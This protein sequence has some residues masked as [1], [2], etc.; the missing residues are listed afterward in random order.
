[1]VTAYTMRA[2][3]R[4]CEASGV[5]TTDG[6]V[7]E[8]NGQ[9]VV[10]CARCNRHV[11]N[12]PRLETGRAVRTVTT[13]HNGIKPSQRARVLERDGRCILCGSRDGLHVGHLLSVAAG[14]E[15]GLTEAQLNDDENLAAMCAECN[16]GYGQRSV[17]LWIVV[18]LLRARLRGQR[19]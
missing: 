3:C 16:L 5:I 12:A 18:P 11:Y 6:T 4:F 2:A 17:P 14:L 9:D 8:V 15:A 1:M 10:R 13:V 19:T 7:R